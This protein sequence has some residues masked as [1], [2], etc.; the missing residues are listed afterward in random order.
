MA[1]KQE[2]EASRF[3]QQFCRADLFRWK[4]QTESKLHKEKPRGILRAVLRNFPVFKPFLQHSTAGKE[5]SLHLPSANRQKA[6]LP[7]RPSAP[8]HA[9]GWAAPHCSGAPEGSAQDAGSHKSTSA[10]FLKDEKTHG[11]STKALVVVGYLDTT[12]NT[13]QVKSKE[14]ID[15][16]KSRKH[17]PC[18]WRC[19]G[20]ENRN[21]STIF[22]FYPLIFGSDLRG[23]SLFVIQFYMRQLCGEGSAPWTSLRSSHYPHSRNTGWRT[24]LP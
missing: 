20:R 9:G 12:R 13:S 3:P 14:L 7:L 23:F 5:D 11:N 16:L 2:A 4:Q 18:F 24:C 15:L 17:P 8:A 1:A 10:P 22:L 6:P 19:E 21:R